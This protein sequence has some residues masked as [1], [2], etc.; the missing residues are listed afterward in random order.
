MDTLIDADKQAMPVKS[1][2]KRERVQLMEVRPDP[3]WFIR[4]KDQDGHTIWF[5][6]FEMTGLRP[7]RY[8]QF[9]TKHKAVLFLDRLIDVLGDG[10]SEAA[11]WLDTYQLKS[12]PYA[13]RGGHYPVVED[14]LIAAPIAKKG[15]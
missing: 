10:F 4:S 6:K 12:R 13:N 7:R 2:H 9:P 5:L 15:R 14:E 1:K 11:N 8:G 3:S